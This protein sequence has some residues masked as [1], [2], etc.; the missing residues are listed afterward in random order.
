YFGQ[1]MT[2]QRLFLTHLPPIYLFEAIQR[3]ATYIRNILALL[4]PENKE[5]LINYFSDW[6]NMKQGELENMIAASTSEEYNHFEINRVL[7]KMM[8]FMETITS[9]FDTL[10]TL[11]YVG[12]RRDTQIYIKEETKPKKSFLADD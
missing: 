9:L 10:S 5:E 11:E 7:S 1:H 2:E 3:F 12:K 4:P 6:C 8:N